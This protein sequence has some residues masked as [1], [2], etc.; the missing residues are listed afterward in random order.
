MP[1]NAKYLYCKC[2]FFTCCLF[3]EEK[4]I[5]LLCEFEIKTLAKD[6][7]IRAN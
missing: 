4:S 6:Q 5:S 1:I 2:E 7:R 3:V